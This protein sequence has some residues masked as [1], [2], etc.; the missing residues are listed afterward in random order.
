MPPLL[1]ILFLAAVLILVI[2]T[3]I[4]LLDSKDRP[5]RI[6]PLHKFDFE[7]GQELFN[8]LPPHERSQDSIQISSQRGRI[9]VTWKISPR[10]ENNLANLIIRI[11]NS[12]QPRSHSDAAARDWQGKLLFQSKTGIAYY[13][14]VGFKQNGEFTPLLLSAPVLGGGKPWF[15]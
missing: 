4:T 5:D 6:W 12:S 13:A 7:A 11:Y 3:T 14:A 8:Y 10:P 15:H 9:M 2:Y 1:F